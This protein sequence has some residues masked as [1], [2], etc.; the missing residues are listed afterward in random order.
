M[1]GR[2]RKVAILAVVLALGVAGLAEAAPELGIVRPVN[3]PPKP[4]LTLGSELFAANCA[5]CHGV[6]GQGIY[7]ARP[8]AGDILGQGPP[9]RGVG[10]QAA[11]LYLRLGFMP[12]S[13]HHDEPNQGPVEFSPKEV[14]SLIDYVASLGN[15]PGIPHPHPAR[16]SLSEGMQAFTLHCAGCHQMVAEGGYA[17]GAK[18]PP[19]RSS[20]L[21]PTLIAEAVRVGPYVMP[22]FSARQIPGSQLNA[23][24]HYVLY[25]KHIPNRGGWRIGNLGP[26]PEGMVAWWIAVPL[27]II[28]CMLV[29]RRYRKVNS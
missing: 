25:M 21:T 13:D 5:S 12:L 14:R 9:L 29:A 3:E 1:K 10:A 28:A 24:I 20:R 17:T 26:I 11:D 16:A 19:L 27:L 8:G 6:N 2:R 15:G 7:R 4:S 18:V 23:I 22:S